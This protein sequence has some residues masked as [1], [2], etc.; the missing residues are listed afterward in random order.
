MLDSAASSVGNIDIISCHL[1]FPSH[2]ICIYWRS[3]ISGTLCLLVLFGGFDVLSVG[4][5]SEFRRKHRHNFVSFGFSLSLPYDLQI[6]AAFASGR[7]Y[8]LVL[9]GVSDV[10][11]VGFSS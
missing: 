8:L 4:F 2:M 6:L 9:F 3:L 1:A 11:S 10:L 5:S 7:L